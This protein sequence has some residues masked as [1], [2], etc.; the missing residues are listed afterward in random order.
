[1]FEKERAE[2][3][4]KD[5]RKLVSINSIID[6]DRKVQDEKEDI[7]ED[8]KETLENEVQ[9]VKEDTKKDTKKAKKK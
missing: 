8:A 1:M 6:N 3:L 9:D 7:A 4:L 5:E 2:E